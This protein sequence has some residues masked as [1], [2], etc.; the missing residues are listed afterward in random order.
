M[1]QMHQTIDFNQY[2]V[3]DGV[4]EYWRLLF[5]TE[6]LKDDE[7][8]RI[9]FQAKVKNEYRGKFENIKDFL[10]T[11]NIQ[12]RSAL[13]LINYLKNKIITLP[14]H[15]CGISISTGIFD[16]DIN[17]LNEKGKVK[18]PSINTFKKLNTIVLDI[19]AHIKGSKERFPI[20]SLEENYQKMV[21]ARSYVET[22]SILNQFGIEAPIPSFSMVTGGG[23]QIA[24][25]FDQDLYA[26]DA[27]LIFNRLGAVLG[28][29]T[30]GVLVKDL[31][32]NFSEAIMDFDASFKDISHTQRAAG[33]VHQKYGNIPNFCTIG[34]TGIFDFFNQD[35]LK[36][37]FQNIISE[38]DTE[39]LSSEYT[40]IQK[41]TFENYYVKLVQSFQKISTKIQE[42]DFKKDILLEDAR[43][44]LAQSKNNLNNLNTNPF[45]Y[46]LIQNLKQKIQDGLFNLSELFPTVNFEDHGSY[47]KINCLFHEETKPSM[48]IYKNSL[49]FEDFHDSQSYSIIEAYMKINELTKGDAINKIADLAN[50]K[51]K[52]ADRKEFEKMEMTELIEVLLDKIDQDNY[53]YYRLSNKNRACIIRH[54]DSG[55]IYSFDGITM[56]SNHVLNNQLNVTDVDYEFHKEFARAF[57]RK[58][59]IEAFEE[60]QPGKPTVFQRNF[61]KFVNLWVPSKNYEK[62]KSAKDVLQE[63]FPDQLDINDTIIMLRQKTPWTFKYILQ[64]VQKGDLEWFINWLT[65]TANHYV[66]PTIPV[67]FGVP[68]AGKNLFVST[69][70]EW[71][72]NGEFTKILS[73]DRLMSNFNSILE[74]C[75]L[76]VLDEG[77]FS[78]QKSNDALKLITGSDK[79]LIEKKGVDTQSKTKKLNIMMFSNGQVPARHP[80]SDRRMVYFNSEITLL[81]LTES[82]GLSIEDFISNVKKELEDFWAIILNTKLDK[83]KAMTNLKNAT[84][85]IQILRQHPAGELILKMLDS[86]WKEIGLQLNENVSDPIMM[87]NNLELL[88]QIK[89]QF[90]KSGSISLTLINRYLQSLNYRVNTSVQRFLGNNN[91]E[92]FGISIE[93][94]NSEVILVINKKKLK[95][96]LKIDNIILEEIPEITKKIKRVQTKIKKMNPSDAL[97]AGEKVL[98]EEEVEYQEYQNENNSLIPEP[99]KLKN[100]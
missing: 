67:F 53:V 96:S 41:K 17:N 51:F 58:I 45:E 35:S 26:G 100:L 4:R 13:E 49:K 56:L 69:I 95:E 65:A 27:K 40:D 37:L 31:M 46:E 25:N 98:A 64:L 2:M 33:I 71:F 10:L 94:K 21:I 19:D 44:D 59:L 12:I 91:L 52:K 74:S 18:A 11:E 80:S 7:T 23:I 82:L 68:G 15:D 3:E 70:L 60:F 77:D 47:W 22:V 86:E 72:V 20:H 93:I 57:E 79:L 50:I 36:S 88:E 66:L 73:T 28:K 61:I 85:W 29:K 76:M 5:K 8:V 39:I 87:K 30:F 99:P 6:E 42:L 34:T 32:G 55:E 90:S 14:Y 84:F 78:T 54:I 97:S 38:I 83:P 48:A 81:E 62:A 43:I 24:F 9:V 89:D 75:S 63:E 16:Y 92:F 1:Q